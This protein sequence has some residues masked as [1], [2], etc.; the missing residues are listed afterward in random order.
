[1]CSVRPLVKVKTDSFN[2]KSEMSQLSNSRFFILEPQNAFLQLYKQSIVLLF[3][4]TW[5]LDFLN[6]FCYLGP[7]FC[8]SL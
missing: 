7:F 4:Y 3:S 8:L 1:M 5:L 6:N 2:S